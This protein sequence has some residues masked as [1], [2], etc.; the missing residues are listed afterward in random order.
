MR[1]LSVEKPYKYDIYIAEGVQPL[2]EVFGTYF[3]GVKKAFIVTDSNVFDTYGR[4]FDGA[5]G[6]PCQYFVMDSGEQNKSFDTYI[7]II[8]AMNGFGLTRGDLVIAF[9]GGVVGDIAGFAASTYMRGVKLF[10]V[11]TTILSMV[12]SAVGGKT[13]VDF[14]GVKN[15]VGTFYAPICVFINT[16]FAHSLDDRQ[17][18]SGYGEIIKYCLLGAL[19]EIQLAA[20]FGEEVVE[21]C[22]RFKKG[23][24]ERDMKESGERRILNLGHTF[25]HA[26]ESLSGYALTHGECVVKGLDF[27]LRA[28]QKLFGADEKLK[29]DRQTILTA[30]GHDLSCP[31]SLERLEK[32]IYKDKKFDGEKINFVALDNSGKPVVR[33]MTIDKLVGLLTQ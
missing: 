25:G 6:I 11:P 4:L 24:V 26:I 31:F 17:I 15:L 22:L 7:K 13:A 29:A 10:A 30:K 8:S 19:S 16:S 33:Q 20:P 23:V 5:L 18:K 2:G 12:D 32:Q 28:S 1:V 3:S 21:A 27:T 14:C 9:G